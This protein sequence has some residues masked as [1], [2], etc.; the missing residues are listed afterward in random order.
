MKSLIY[1]MKYNESSKWKTFQYESFDLCIRAM[2]SISFHVFLEIL[3]IHAKFKQTLHIHIM[4][5]NKL[6]FFSAEGWSDTSNRLSSAFNRIWIFFKNIYTK[7]Y[8]QMK[9][10]DRMKMKSTRRTFTLISYEK[11]FYLHHICKLQM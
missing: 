5:H 8:K 1:E 11:R 6:F 10:S 2:Y 3:C 9:S 7:F 4:L